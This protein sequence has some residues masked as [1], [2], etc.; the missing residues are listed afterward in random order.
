[1]HELCAAASTGDLPRARALNDKL[2]DLHRDLFIEPSPTPTKWALQ[3]M[4]LI[5]GGIRLPLL[6]L[7]S[8]AQA[9]ILAALQ[10]AG[11]TI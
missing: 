6:P 2:L 7:S 3:R 9:R 4:G 10:S 11:I 1:M 5:A 8:A